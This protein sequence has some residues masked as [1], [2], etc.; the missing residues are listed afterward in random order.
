MICTH[1]HD[2]SSNNLESNL[3]SPQLSQKTNKMHSGPDLYHRNLL[4]ALKSNLIGLPEVYD[5]QLS[6]AKDIAQPN[7]SHPDVP[8]AVSTSHII[9]LS[10]II[11]HVA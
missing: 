1:G 10:L 5:W 6:L 3:W 11:V 2:Q 8:R 9:D 7:L 4:L